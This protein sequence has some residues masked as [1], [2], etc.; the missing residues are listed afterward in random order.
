[1]QELR[2]RIDAARRGV[3]LGDFQWTDNTIVARVTAVRA[4][5]LRELRTALSE[6]YVGGG[7][8]APAYT[9]PVIVALLTPVK[10]VHFTELQAAVVALDGE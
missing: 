3:D 2:D 8:T 9:D 1:M 10:A 6:A 5:H 7:R 4:V